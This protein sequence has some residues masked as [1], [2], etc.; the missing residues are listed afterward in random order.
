MLLVTPDSELS[1][2]THSQAHI[3]QNIRI[4]TQIL[5]L[6]GSLSHYHSTAHVT[7]TLTLVAPPARSH[8]RLSRHPIIRLKFERQKMDDMHGARL[9]LL[10]Q[11][12]GEH[13]LLSDT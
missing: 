8:S 4:T 5:V 13:L 6:L 1:P 2:S 9:L 7:I 11:W 12:S 10:L 3:Y